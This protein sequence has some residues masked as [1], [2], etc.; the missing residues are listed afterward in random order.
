[1]FNYD[2]QDFELDAIDEILAKEWT[3][4]SIKE[5]HSIIKEA[6]ETLELETEDSYSEE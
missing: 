1:M 4:L 2:Y 6:K 3:K 5:K